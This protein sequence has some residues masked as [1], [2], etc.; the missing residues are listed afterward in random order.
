MA[1][2]N[3]QLRREQLISPFGVGA[4]TV[5]PDGT[6]LIVAGLDHWFSGKSAQFKN[7]CE[8]M[9]W[10]LAK[11]LGVEQLFSPPSI[12]LSSDSQG[13]MNKYVPR[14]PTLRFPTWYFCRICRKMKQMALDFVGPLRCD[15]SYH[16][17]RASK[18]P[19]MSQ[20]PYIV[21]CKSGHIDDFP[22]SKWCHKSINTS[23]SGSLRF[24]PS[25]S[26]NPQGTR[27]YCDS[28]SAT[29]NLD[30]ISSTGKTG[31]SYVSTNVQSG[32]EL[33]C[34]GSRPWLGSP[35]RSTEKCG[36]DIWGSFRGSSNVYYPLVENSIYI[37]ASEN[38]LPEELMAL[39]NSRQLSSIKTFYEKDSQAS[40]GAAR[41]LDNKNNYGL[42]VFSDSQVAEGYDEI[43]GL[44]ESN[45]SEVE[46][47]SWQNYLSKEY[48]LFKKTLEN[49]R[50]IIQEPDGTYGSV[51]ADNFEKVKLVPVLVETS[52]MWGFT[53]FE[54]QPSL[55]FDSGKKMLSLRQSNVLGNKS[56]LPAKQVKGEGIF[57]EFSSEKLK[58]WANQKPVQER[59]KEIGVNDFTKYLTASGPSATYTLIHT[60][61]HLLIK[62]LVFFCGY[63]ES[64]LKERVYASEGE[65]GMHGLLIYTASGDSE[66]TLGGLV[67]M[68]RPGLLE[69]VIEQA[70]REAEWCSNDPIC[71]ESTNFDG[72]STGRLSACYACC[73]IPET[74]CES[75]N[76][77]LDRS[78]ISNS[79]NTSLTYF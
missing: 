73:L 58:E 8:L 53:R 18:P 42:S 56:W 44:V 65:D 74:A 55:N 33:L 50:L 6:S 62:Q 13:S 45:A 71:S 16:V 43:Y 1:N 35:E 19:I 28:C 67:R 66:G 7:D 57:F 77:F 14:V 63:N 17:G 5:L 3:N 68:G 39:L 75:F 27:V 24:A 78:L 54:S 25:D 29:R 32:E 60:L 76:S 34:S 23:C 30:F 22:W 37:P 10:R 52:A 20:V 41:K 21:I 2:Y 47:D 49:D 70:L 36:L 38:A 15:D 46:E 9:D 26:S 31:R 61:S 69:Q 11:R 12:N 4:L 79:Y 64:S 72:E 51:V 40:T 48:E 59:L